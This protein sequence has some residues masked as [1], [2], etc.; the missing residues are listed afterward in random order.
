MTS[1]TISSSRNRW[2]KC[3]HKNAK[4]RMQENLSHKLSQGRLQHPRQSNCERLWDG[5]HLNAGRDRAR[6]LRRGHQGRIQLAG[7]LD[8]EQCAGLGAKAG[9]GRS[10]CNS[11]RLQGPR[12]SPAGA[13]TSRARSPS[14]SGRSWGPGP[15]ARSSAPTTT[16]SRPR[17]SRHVGAGFPMSTALGR[18]HSVF[19]IT[20]LL[21]VPLI[22]CSRH[23]STKRKTPWTRWG[24]TLFS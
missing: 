4:E 9:V 13:S 22:D 6:A 11:R 3:D 21:A 15:A 14:V 24:R 2:D 20:E 16:E 18:S 7:P 17:R 23:N 1:P 8:V 12:Q 10:G 5:L 19:D